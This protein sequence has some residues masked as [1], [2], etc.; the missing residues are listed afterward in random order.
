[1]P[2]GLHEITPETALRFDDENGI[3]FVFVYKRIF[4]GFKGEWQE[5]AS[6]SCAKEW[7]E[8]PYAKM[9]TSETLQEVITWFWI[10]HTV[11]MF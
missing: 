4:I 10:D 6:F 3:L 8:S 9:A 1:M 5:T 2:T 11:T 7:D